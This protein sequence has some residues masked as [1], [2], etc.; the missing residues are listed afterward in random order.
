MRL[1]FD[2]QTLMASLDILPQAKAGGF[3][4]Q[5]CDD[6]PQQIFLAAL[7]LSF[8]FTFHKSTLI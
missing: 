2:D 1:F 7:I 8:L 5:D 4:L 6:P 3:R